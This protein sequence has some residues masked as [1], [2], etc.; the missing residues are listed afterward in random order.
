MREEGLPGPRE[1]EAVPQG[2]EILWFG[3]S[4]GP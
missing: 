4:P 3:E 1:F 2:S